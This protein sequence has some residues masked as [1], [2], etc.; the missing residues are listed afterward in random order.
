MALLSEDKYLVEL[1]RHLRQLP[2]YEEGMRF[3]ANPAG[4]TGADVRGYTWEGPV[5]KP[6]V[7]AT[8]AV[9]AAQQHQIR[10][11]PRK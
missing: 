10:V 11:T 5:D 3:I 8:A 7:F 2:D 9:N 6:L 4:A 1:N